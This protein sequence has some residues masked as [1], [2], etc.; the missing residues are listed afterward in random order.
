MESYLMRLDDGSWPAI[1]Q[2]CGRSS[3]K[4]HHRRSEFWVWR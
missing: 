3:S 4:S 2:C 1:F